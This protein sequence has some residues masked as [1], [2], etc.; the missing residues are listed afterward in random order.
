MLGVKRHVRKLSSC[1]ESVGCQTLEIDH[2]PVVLVA[3]VEVNRF[4]QLGHRCRPLARMVVG[5]PCEIEASTSNG[6]RE[7]SPYC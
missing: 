2:T 6:F 5:P 4:C 1:P 7:A 3:I